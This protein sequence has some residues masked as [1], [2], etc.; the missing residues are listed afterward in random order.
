ML[1]RTASRRISRTIGI[2]LLGC[3]GITQALLGDETL[4]AFERSITHDYAKN[5]DVA[6]HY[7]SA[8]KGPLMIMIHGFPDFWYTW[9]HQMH[10]LSKHYQTVAVDQ[11]G[12]NLSDK[13][14]KEDQFKIQHLVDDIRA[15]IKHTGNDKAIIVGHDWGGFVAWNVAMTYPDMTEKLVILN[16]PH[17]VALA[18]EL[19]SNPKQQANSE[20]ARRFQKDDAHKALTAAGLANWVTDIDARKTYVKAFERSSFEG[21]L[22]FYKANYPRPPYQAHKGPIIKVECPVLMFHGLDDW[23]LL[24]GGLNGTWEFL[25]KDLT[26]VTL[27]GAGHFVQQ[28]RS[29]RVSKTILSWLQLQESLQ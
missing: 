5:G 28:D 11:R 14:A 23:A 12:Y 8:G 20:Y 7:T 16:L 21:M 2:L 13:P 15:V 18:R 22:N 10:Y 6:I 27:P 24:P 25:E 19:A 1:S 17:P 29:E 4:E 9:R 3:L 26:L